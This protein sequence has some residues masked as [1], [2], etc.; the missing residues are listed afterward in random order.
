MCVCLPARP[1]PPAL[2][3]VLSLPTQSLLVLRPL[4]STHP[5]RPRARVAVGCVSSLLPGLVTFHA[6]QPQGW[7]ENE[8]ETDVVF[9]CLHRCE[10]PAS[11]C[12]AVSAM[13]SA[14][15]RPEFALH[16]PSR[17]NN[18]RSSTAATTSRDGTPRPLPSPPPPE[19][20]GTPFSS[21]TA[22]F[23]RVFS[24]LDGL[25]CWRLMPPQ[26]RELIALNPSAFAGA[27]IARAAIVP[28]SSSS[29]GGAQGAQSAGAIAESNPRSARSSS[30]LAAEGG[31]VG[32][33]SVRPHTSLA[34]AQGRHAGDGATVSSSSSSSCLMPAR[35]RGEPVGTRSFVAGAGEMPHLND[36]LGRS[37]EGGEAVGAGGAGGAGAGSVGGGPSA[38]SWRAVVG[39][40]L[41]G[42]M[43]EVARG[44]MRGAWGC[45]AVA[46]RASS[47][48]AILLCDPAYAPLP[49]MVRALQDVVG[50]LHAARMVRDAFSWIARGER[51]L[52]DSA[53]AS[54]VERERRL[55]Q[56]GSLV[57]S[58]GDLRRSLPMQ[59]KGA[60]AGAAASANSVSE[61]NEAAPAATAGT[62]GGSGDAGVSFMRV[63]VEQMEVHLV[64]VLD[65][66]ASMPLPECPFTSFKME[67]GFVCEHHAEWRASAGEEGESGGEPRGCVTCNEVVRPFLDNPYEC[68]TSWVPWN[69]T[70]GEDFSPAFFQRLGLRCSVEGDAV[71]VSVPRQVMDHLV[72]RG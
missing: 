31:A 40:T 10:D 21:A 24:L 19:A 35:G 43:P 29:S 48:R 68:W 4:L 28:A 7:I 16:L 8:E 45:C 12:R 9:E 22:F 1:Q 47:Y 53:D 34:G 6:E 13:C 37:G 44:R 64:R 60:G 3:A 33:G 65:A 41:A 58:L 5:F 27:V 25:D 14:L 49:L 32:G 18:R 52:A 15:S 46:D 11:A 62:G 71:K 57:W 72:R 42:A 36:A 17:A 56:L 63:V 30:G 26:L 66:T 69:G 67:S 51:E 61:G 50:D 23:S 39:E 70:D 2:P 54:L 20:V 55:D 38:N 59:N